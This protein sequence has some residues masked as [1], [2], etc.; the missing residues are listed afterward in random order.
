MAK[1]VNRLRAFPWWALALAALILLFLVGFVAD[2]Y[3]FRSVGAVFKTALG[4]ALG[5]YAHLHLVCQ[6]NHIPADDQSAAAQS[7]RLSRAIVMAACAI[8]VAMAP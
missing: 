2:A 8:G 4:L 7:K 3:V 1:K 6:G 5:Y